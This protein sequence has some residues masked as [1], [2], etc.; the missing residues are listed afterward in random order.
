MAPWH[1][2]RMVLEAQRLMAFSVLR[3]M[4][5]T[6]TP[7][8]G[9]SDPNARITIEGSTASRP[10]K[11]VTTH[12]PI[13]ISAFSPATGVLNEGERQK[14]LESN[15]ADLTRF[16]RRGNR[17]VL[18]PSARRPAPSDRCRSGTGTAINGGSL[19]FGRT[20]RSK[21]LPALT[22]S[23]KAMNRQGLSALARATQ[24]AKRMLMKLR[25]TRVER[26]Q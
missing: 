16:G 1:A 9:L 21:T 25:T 12:Q 20:G 17:R 5:A 23:W 26:R 6:H 22:A 3:F 15:A 4:S 18:S 7:T 10:L 2:T 13:G 11:T 24:C 8:P 19:Q 14:S